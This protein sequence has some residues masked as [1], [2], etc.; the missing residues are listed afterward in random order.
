[1]FI[2]ILIIRK[3]HK[4]YQLAVIFISLKFFQISL[5]WC[6]RERYD[7]GFGLFR[8]GIGRF[9]ECDNRFGLSIQILWFN[10]LLLRKIRR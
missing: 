6:F 4:I 10:R 5:C 7:S 3:I 8:F 9:V 1:M 2:D